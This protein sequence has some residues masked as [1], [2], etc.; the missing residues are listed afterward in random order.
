MS[1]RSFSK[2]E[3]AEY[4][5]YLRG[6]K[7]PMAQKALQMLEHLQARVEKLEG[8]LTKIASCQSHAKGDVVDIARAALRNDEENGNG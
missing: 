5:E 2:A 8:A 7:H 4:A 1:A 3:I 6:D